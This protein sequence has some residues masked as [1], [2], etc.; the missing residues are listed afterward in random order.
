MMGV[1]QVEQD[2]F[3]SAN[4]GNKKAKRKRGATQATP[5]R[6]LVI[7]ADEVAYVTLSGLQWHKCSS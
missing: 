6:G 2:G 3:T 4:V 5:C 1:T 7:G